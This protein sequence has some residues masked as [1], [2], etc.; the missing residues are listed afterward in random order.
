MKILFADKFPPEYADLLTQRG[1]QC[2]Y[3]PLLNEEDLP[4]ALD[5]HQILVVRST[6]VSAITYANAPKLKLV[7]R[8]GAGTNTI[9]L[10]AATKKQ[11][12]VCNVPGRNAAAV[13]ELTMGLLLCIDRRIPDNV[14]DLRNGKWNKRSYSVAEGV[15][16]KTMAIIGLGAIGMAVAQRAHAFGIKLLGLYKPGRSAEAAHK[17]DSLG[18]EMV[19]DMERMVARADIVSVHVPAGL[20]T[21]HLI[22][23]P[24]LD[25]MRPGA[26]LLNTS[27]G[28]VVDEDA[29]IHAIES[30]DIRAGLDVYAN[31]PPQTEALFTSPLSRHA[32]V[33]GTHHIGAST[34]QAQAA[35]SEGVIEVIDA[36]VD[37]Q[38]INNVNA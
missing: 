26:I 17:L 28:D 22:N 21:K 9:D 10:P 31:E 16:G 36:F 32:N 3:Q 4:D 13:A 7:I 34:A 30:K 6:R 27:R 1:H 35:V 38:I 14:D 11:I 12:S 5:D 18:F 24:L 37:G 8:A 33:Y 25:Q 29:L 19:E 15:Y 2:D 20:D 23:G